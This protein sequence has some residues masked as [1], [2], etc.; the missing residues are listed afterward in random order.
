MLYELHIGAFTKEGTF[1]A[2]ARELSRLKDLGV[3]AVEVMPISQFP[4][5]RNWG[6]DGV[7]P[8]AAQN[9]Y[10]GPDAFR[11]FVDAAHKRGLAVVL[12]VVYNHLGPEGCRAAEFGP[13]FTDRFQTPWGAAINL[14]GPDSDAVRAFFIQS[15]LWWLEDCR[16]D[17]LRLDAT[18]TLL[19][20]SERPF[21]AE[22]SQ[23]VAGLN[24][25]TN[26]L[27]YLLAEHLRNDSRVVRPRELG[28]LGLDS[29]WTDDLHHSL[30]VALTGEGVGPYAD[31]NGLPDLAKAYAEGWAYDGTRVSGWRGRTF[32]TPS[33]G[34]SG[35]R[36]V[37]YWQNHD[38]VGN[39]TDGAR[40]PSLVSL[41][42]HKLGLA[43]ILLSPCL[44]M[45]FMGDEYGASEP[46]HFFSDF[47]DAGLRE[48]VRQGRE[49]E[50]TVHFGW[51]GTPPDPNALA[52]FESCVLDG[53]RREG[54]AG[55]R[56]TAFV[57]EVLR[58]RREH[59]AFKEP[60]KERMR[61]SFEET[62]PILLIERAA[63]RG[64]IAMHLGDTPY[65]GE[66]RIPAGRWRLILDSSDDRWG[67]PGSSASSAL[68]SSGTALVRL[69]PK[70]LVFYE[71]M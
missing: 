23:A 34:L 55:A 8:S 11:R 41:E 20:L 70:S 63:G 16:V 58:L 66:L 5:A 40:A 9:T 64:F 14:D 22:L 24:R 18:S 59:P 71:S 61:V 47:T 46:F 26:R 67:G 33:A 27:C 2:A 21:L 43:A 28:G 31:F 10:G 69:N 30:H 44:P 17:A 15:A 4:G 51:P 49:R 45:L 38:Q 42:T 35:R 52:T 7:F 53:R 13:Y 19:D 12:D 62:P 57:Q 37:A 3:T 25:R 36:F 54:R 48:A 65:E 6:Y 29:Q 56:V 32:G 1:D 60:C 50:L 39:R 68:A